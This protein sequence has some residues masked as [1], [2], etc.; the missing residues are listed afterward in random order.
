MPIDTGLRTASSCRPSSS[1]MGRTMP[2]FS[3]ARSPMSKTKPS[4]STDCT[5]PP[6]RAC[7]SKSATE[8]PARAA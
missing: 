3:T 6:S 2:A 5:R 4:R 8:R 7:R 1:S